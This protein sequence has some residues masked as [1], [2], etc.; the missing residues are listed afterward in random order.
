MIG[1]IVTWDV[2]SS[3]PAL[4]S[5]LR[6]FVFGH[7]VTVN[8]RLYRYPGF[9][10]KEGVRYLGQSVLF[11]SRQELPA[12]MGFLESNAIESATIPASL[13]AILTN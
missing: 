11:V 2:N 6:R 13:G 12:L 1:F 10:E 9:I 4:C 5:R 8:G 3:D 7:A